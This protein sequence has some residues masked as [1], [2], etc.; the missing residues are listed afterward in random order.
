M[1]IIIL[2][3]EKLDLF[4]EADEQTKIHNLV[5]EKRVSMHFFLLDPNYFTLVY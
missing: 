1:Q 5:E 4:A 2:V 3:F